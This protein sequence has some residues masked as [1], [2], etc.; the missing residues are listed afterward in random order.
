MDQ[1][2][3][4]IVV[5]EK[6]TE[7]IYQLVIYSPELIEQSP[8]PGQ[9]LHVRVS[10]HLE[11]LLRRPISIHD[12]DHLQK[13]CTLIYRVGG[14]GTQFLKEKKMGDSLDILGP[15][16]NG[17]P[18]DELKE[19]EQ[20]VL[21]GGGVGIPPLYYLAKELVKKEISLTILLG[22][23]SKEQSFLVDKFSQIGEVN[24]ATMDGTEGIK[25]T[26]VDLITENLNDNLVQTGSTFYACGPTPMLQSLQNRWL[27]TT[28]KGYLSL[29]ERMG[30]GIG[31]CYGCVIKV[32]PEVDPK[33]YKK[34][35]QEGPVFSF[36]EVQL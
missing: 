24:I 22:Y 10:E 5:N 31:A 6:I 32:D 28:I 18:M 25:G 4:R 8:L 16:G 34:I 9:F 33:G 14:K 11:P 13:Q 27:D 20:V 7:E 15:L 21:L 36:R 1:I 29:E 26:V 3:A 35:C 12:I 23:N 17:F 2:T 30:C 19:G